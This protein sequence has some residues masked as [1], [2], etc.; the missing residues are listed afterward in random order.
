MQLLTKMVSDHYY[1]K[2]KPVNSVLVL[3]N[4]KIFYDLSK[5]SSTYKCH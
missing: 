5:Q 1:T 2:L 3:L 4:S